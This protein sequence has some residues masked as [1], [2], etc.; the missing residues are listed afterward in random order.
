MNKK[1]LIVLI[2]F[3]IVIIFCLSLAYWEYLVVKS[4]E[5]AIK[6]LCDGLGMEYG[7]YMT[8]HYCSD[9]EKRLYVNCVK[10]DEMNVWRCSYG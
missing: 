7:Q 1:E 4:K 10:D 5:A 3:I 8:N 2:C 6:N 9:G